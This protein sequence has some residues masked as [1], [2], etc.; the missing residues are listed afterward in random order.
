MQKTLLCPIKAWV[1]D[2][3]KV[4]VRTIYQDTSLRL[5]FL[6][7]CHRITFSLDHCGHL[8]SIKCCTFEVVIQSYIIFLRAYNKEYGSNYSKDADNLLKGRCGNF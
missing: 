7:F 8:K 4:R 2:M 1:S 3:R 6:Y 5:H